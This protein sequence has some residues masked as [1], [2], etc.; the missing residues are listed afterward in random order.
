MKRMY[1]SGRIVLDVPEGTFRKLR[2]D[3]GAA[4]WI[5]FLPTVGDLGATQSRVQNGG[6]IKCWVIE[7]TD[8]QNRPYYE[9]DSIVWS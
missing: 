7:K 2:I 1:I 5:I 4:Q 8:S 9:V 3:N 6:Q